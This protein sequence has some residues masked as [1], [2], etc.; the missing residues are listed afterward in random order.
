M[1][2]PTTTSLSSKGQIVIPKDIRK[3]LKLKPGSQFVVVAEGDV[4]ILKLIA[5]PPMKDLDSLI[6]M[7]GAQARQVGLDKTRTTAAMAEL[8]DRK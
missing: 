3:K 1:S 6:A 2:I 4:V 5:P 7:A 8:Q